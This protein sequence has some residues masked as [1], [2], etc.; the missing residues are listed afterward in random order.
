VSANACNYVYQAALALQHAHEHGMVHRDIKPS[1]LMLARQGSRAVIK[2]LDFGLAKVRSEGPTDGSLTHEG[3]MLGTP[4]FISPEQIRNARG[5]DIRADI[6]SLGCTLYY[7]LTGAPPFQGTSL[8]DILQAHHSMEAKPLNLARPEV[9]VELAALVAKMMA[10][11]P[12]R[13]F[14][15]PKEVAQALSPFFKKGAVAFQGPGADISQLGHTLMDRPAPGLVSTPTQPATSDEG[16]GVRPKVAAEPSASETQWKSLLDLGQTQ[17]SRVDKPAP[18]PVTRHRPRWLWP[19]VAAGALL[20]GLLGTYGVILRLRTPNG[21]IELANLP[22]DAEVFVDGTEAAV[23]WPGGGKPAVITVLPGQHKVM[24]KKDGVEISGDEVTVQAGSRAKF[25][26]R[27]VSGTEPTPEVP[28]ASALPSIE[29]SIGM[30][31]R[32]IPAG[33]FLMGSPDDDSEAYPPEKP[34]HRVRITKPFYLG[35][36]EVTQAQYKA[37]M[38]NNPSHFSASG[39]GKDQVAG[40][41]TDHC[42]VEN[43][44]WFD[45]IKFCNKLSEKEG[46]KPFYEIDILRV[47]DLNGQGYRLPT[48]AEWEYACRANGPSRTSYAFGDNWWGLGACAW[49]AFNSEQRTHPVGQK[50]P[51]SFGLYDMHGNVYEW[52]CDWHVGEYY[53][54]SPTDDP[55][56]PPV[57]G[58]RAARGGNFMDTPRHCRSAQRGNAPPDV[59]RDWLGFRVVLGAP[60]RRAPNTDSAGGTGATPASEKSVVS[61]EPAPPPNTKTDLVSNPETLVNTVGMKLK[62]IPAGTFMMGSPDNALESKD[63][64]RPLHRVRITRPFYMGACEVTQAQYESVMGNNPSHFAPTGGGSD[65]VAGQSTAECPVDNVTWFQAIRFCN[66]LSE[67][68]GKKPFY[69]IE[70]PKVRVPD[71]NG[72][73]YRLPT[74]AEWEYACRANASPQTPFSFGDEISKLALHAWFGGNS[75]ART[76]PVGQK[77]PNRFGLYD[78]HGNVWEWCWDWHIGEYYAQS[79]ADDPIGPAAT[80]RVVRGGGWQANPR[81][82][83]SAERQ[84]C[85][86]GNLH[87]DN[88]FRV[89]LGALQLPVPKGDSMGGSGASPA[90]EKSVVRQEPAPP[91]NVK[92][93]MLSNP[94]T[95]A[96]TVGMKL[97]LI[98]AGT[99]M[100][101]SPD[102]AIEA[103]IVE[104]PLHRVLITKPFYMGAC[105][106]TQAQYAA[107]TGKNP[108]HFAASGAGKDRVTGQSTDDFPVENVSWFDAIRFCNKLSEREGKKP[109]YEIDGTD[110]RVPDW[111]GQGYRLPTEAEWEYAC[112]ANTSTQMRFSFGD[113]VQEFPSYGWFRANSEERSHAVGQ[114][115]PNQFGLYDMHG[116]LWEWCWDWSV[117]SF[118]TRSPTADPVGPAQSSDRMRRGGSWGNDPRECRSAH[119]LGLPPNIADWTLGFRVALGPSGRWGPKAGSA[120]GAAALPASRTSGRV[121]GPA[122]TS[123]EV[124]G[125]PAGKSKRARGS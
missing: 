97:K 120:G 65:R 91:P 21:T 116:N 115:R 84:P 74:E 17:A 76:H 23:T 51:N 94:E 104:R 37:V 19:A 41:S 117:T 61:Q 9:P 27:V 90:S 7:L 63:D 96:N 95:L 82:C 88:G 79:S 46:K 101:G 99:F 86:P 49:Y 20:L 59:R 10:K 18:A 15:E 36:C 40:Q 69:L 50:R 92:T 81:Q 124:P 54:Q 35:V 93:Q 44:S 52:C 122:S 114:K 80:Y 16:P 108:S 107:V 34:L 4:D 30:T 5:A 109:F 85:S 45:A 60:E 89:A 14:Q 1:N 110:V 71:W 33:E 6:Y 26:V 113:R 106:V 62:L 42:P 32:L 48:E 47:P 25:T 73:G 29:N 13:R 24:V 112:R 43:V 2:V 3:Q 100:M 56:G 83:R 103:E 38:G 77:R 8:Y 22:E 123:G 39:A 57:A 11:E 67:K 87:F 72:Q 111:K 125:T 78:M 12:E 105:E 66:N 75:E 31:L 55:N 64:E 70:G 102:D 121:R 58:E 119:R 68:E 28:K 118:Y 98:P 53:G